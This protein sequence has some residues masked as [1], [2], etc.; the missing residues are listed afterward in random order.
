MVS[1]K[2]LQP[3]NPVIPAFAGM[4]KKGS[5]LNNYAFTNFYT[6]VKTRI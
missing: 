4:T 1:Y 6:Q 5:I 3:S 2:T